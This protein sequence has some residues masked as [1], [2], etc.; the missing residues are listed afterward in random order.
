M[1]KIVLSCIAASLFFAG[2][3]A[4]DS[5]LPLSN[6]ATFVETYSPSEVTI[7]ATGLGKNDKE[8]IPRPP[9]MRGQFRSHARHRP[10]SVDTGREE[11]V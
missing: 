2:A 3:V 11:P 5:N 1:N 7:Q 10:T 8:A 9:Q 6:Q 4:K